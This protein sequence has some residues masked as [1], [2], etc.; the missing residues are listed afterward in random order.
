MKAIFPDPEDA[1][2]VIPATQNI[3]IATKRTDDCRMI[4][5][6]LLRD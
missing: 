3:V 2:A 4:M 1:E 5:A 6:D